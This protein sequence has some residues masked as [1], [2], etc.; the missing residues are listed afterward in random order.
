MAELDYTVSSSATSYTVDTANN[1]IVAGNAYSFIVITVN[2]VG[3]SSSSD[4]LE[5]I[6]AG[7]PPGVPL[8]LRRASGVT[9]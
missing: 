6:V 1:G 8:N 3:D 5:S 2:V 7:S 9:P 4:I